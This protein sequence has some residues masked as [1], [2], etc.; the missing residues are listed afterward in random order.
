M[1]TESCENCKCRSVVDRIRLRRDQNVEGDINIL[2]NVLQE[3]HTSSTHREVLDECVSLVAET[4]C[5]S[6]ISEIPISLV[7]IDEKLYNRF[8]QKLI[9]MEMWEV[10]HDAVVLCISKGNVKSFQRFLRQSLIATMTNTTESEEKLCKIFEHLPD[11][12]NIINEDDEELVK[13]AIEQ[14]H[15]KVL[16]LLFQSHVN[17]KYLSLRHGD[18]P[19][20]VAAN[21]YLNNESSTIFQDFVVR[22]RGNPIL[23]SF[24][25]PHQTD[26][27]GDNL[28][29]LVAKSESC[30]QAHKLAKLLNGLHVSVSCR[31]NEG[32][33]PRD[34]VQ[35]KHE[36]M[37]KGSAE[38]RE[39]GA[40]MAD[41][42]LLRI[43]F[44]FKE[45]A[46]VFVS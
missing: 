46:A 14:S 36:E 17:P 2:I 5:S 16:R 28:F 37:R 18:T 1:M 7:K 10:M 33:P 13:S 21:M 45:S 22:Y 23:Y 26:A 19:M 38:W 30:P 12:E 43:V 34:Y 4:I 29:H 32:K 11:G 3:H 6:A 44:S 35:C 42:L 27:N 24:L 31:N 20:H 40:K 25:D 8:L 39:S 9:Q 41:T 15:F